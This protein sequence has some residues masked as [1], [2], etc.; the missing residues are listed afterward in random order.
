[1]EKCFRFWMENGSDCSVC[2]GICPFNKQEAWLHEA[3]R[4][5]I[6][7]KSGS[8]DKLL[9]RLDEASGFGQMPTDDETL[10]FWKKKDFI[11]I[12]P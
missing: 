7:A 11:H 4:I 9:G 5:L 8:L 10:E 2:L 12:K 6:G 1:M 3:T